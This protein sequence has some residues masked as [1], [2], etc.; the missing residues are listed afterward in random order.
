MMVC[1]NA[2]SP[3]QRTGSNEVSPPSPKMY[4]TIVRSWVKRKKNRRKEKGKRKKEEVGLELAVVDVEELLGK[5][6]ETSKSR[7]CS[8]EGN[9]LPIVIQKQNG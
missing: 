6:F 1:A 8:P 3:F 5:A 7:M 2:S 4:S 9:S